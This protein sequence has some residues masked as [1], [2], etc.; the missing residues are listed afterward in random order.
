MFMPYKSRY[1]RCQEIADEIDKLIKSEPSNLRAVRE[2]IDK[3]AECR[4]NEE[5]RNA[6]EFGIVIPLRDNSGKE[7]KR[8]TIDRYINDLTKKF[9]GLTIFPHVRGCFYSEDGTKIQCEDNMLVTA[10]AS[11]DEYSR[12]KEWLDKYVER[13]GNDLGQQSV[14]FISTP[15]GREFVPTIFKETIYPE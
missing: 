5:M 1:K 12:L 10:S 7:I 9:G 11:Y 3:Y 2:K 8:E 6:L 4:M 13:I 14:Y 15:V